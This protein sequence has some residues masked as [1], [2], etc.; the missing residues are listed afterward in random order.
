MAHVHG[1]AG[2]RSR[3]RLFFVFC[4]TSVI[5]LVELFVGLWTGSLI[6]LADAA[7]MF[8]D[9][10][11]LGLAL[12]AIWFAGRPAPPQATFGYYRIEIL[13]ALVNALF[14]AIVTFF[15]VREAISRLQAPP[16]IHG[17]PV[18]ITGV[19]G[20]V[21]NLVAVRVLH[22][23]AQHSLNVKGAYLEVLADTLGSVAVIVSA[24]L[25]LQFGWVLADPILTL[26]IGLFMVPR[27]FLLLREATD[28]LMEAAP[29]N[30]DLQDLRRA[31]L[32]QPGVVGLHD[33]HV[34]TITSGRV[35]LSAHVVAEENVD[36]DA[37]INRVNELLRSRY[38]LDHTTL[39]V[40]GATEQATVELDCDPCP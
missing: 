20:L 16:D 36:R 32:Q 18:V 30:L 31:V 6:L 2:Q 14:L 40:E 37:V 22:N 10:A 7:H 38:Q 29:R 21:A 35:C 34:W 13:A 28:V 9:V 19:I 23:D 4:L 25:V 17:I 11:A 3:Q 15:V 8:S 39:Q 24:V 26:L 27:I 5:L 1:S 12:F 33:L